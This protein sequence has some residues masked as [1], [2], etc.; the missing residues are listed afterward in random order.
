MTRPR[1]ELI[2]ELAAELAPRRRL[3]RA[4]AA[5]LG[6]FA[7]AALLVGAATLATGPLRP[8]LLRQLA[9]EPGFG[10]DLLLGALAAGVAVLGLMRLR[11]PGLANGTRAALP[12]LGLFAAWAAWQLVEV[13]SRSAPASGLGQRPGCVFEVLLFALAPLALA[14]WLARRA[15]PL[16]RAWT[17]LLAGVAAGALPALAMQL[18]CRYEPLHA[19]GFHLAPALGVALAGALLGPFVLRRV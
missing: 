2:R 16:Q 10:I 12:A 14:L 11:I 3:A 18:G 4:G 19:L 9:T 7:A 1:A 17:G 15:A 6:W 8:G 13:L 5:A